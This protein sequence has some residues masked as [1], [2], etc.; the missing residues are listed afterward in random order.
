MSLMK[1]LTLGTATAALLSVPL[2]SGSAI[3]QTASGTDSGAYTLDNAAEFTDLDL[4]VDGD[5]QSID[6]T[7]EHGAEE[8]VS[9]AVLEIS[10]QDVTDPVE[11]PLR[12]L[13]VDP[14]NTLGVSA[15][16]VSFGT[17]VT[18]T[19]V[20]TLVV[21]TNMGGAADDDLTITNVG[22]SGSTS[23]GGSLVAGTP[24][25]TLEP[26]E[27]TSLRITFE[28]T[29]AGPSNGAIEV[30]YDD[31]TGTQTSNIRVGGTAQD[32]NGEY[33]PTPDDAEA[34]RFGDVVEGETA[35][36]TV[37]MSNTAPA[38]AG[39]VSIDTVEITN[40]PDGEF[41][42]PDEIFPEDPTDPTLGPGQTRDVPVTVRPAADGVI[43]AN[44][45][46]TYSNGT[47]DTDSYDLT[48][49]G[50]DPMLGIEAVGPGEWGA[51]I[52]VTVRNSTRTN[53]TFD[54]TVRYWTALGET[55]NTA[56][57]TVR[58]Q[59]EPDVE[60]VFTEL[61]TNESSSNYYETVVNS[62]ST[63]VEV[64][65]IGT[66]RPE[67]G[68][69]FLEVP[70]DD[71]TDD[72]VEL[73]HYRGDE[74]AP[75][76]ERTGL[77]GFAETDD[78]SLVSVPD[79]NAI[80][81]LTGEIVSHCENLQD[82]FAIL[83]AT[84]GAD[85]GNLPPNTA[86]SEYAAI[87]YPHIRIVDPETGVRKLV[88]PGGH[89]AGIY[90][91]SDAQ[92]GVWKAPAN[93]TVRG[94]VELERPVTKADQDRLNPN[95][96]NAIRSFPDRGIRV[97][98][99]RTTSVN[100]EWKYINVRR[101]FLFIEESIDEGTQWAVFESNTEELWARV[102]QSVR[103]FLTTVWRNGGLAGTTEDEAFFVKADRTTMTQTDIDNGK[104]IVEVG[105]APVKPAEFV[106]FRI[107]QWT[108]GLEGG[109]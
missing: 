26:G 105:V 102:R 25:M 16:E 75:R 104:L 52:A 86:V 81:G 66:E 51:R 27:T 87:Y 34:L 80:D 72:D 15:I 96:V 76:G 38:G 62:G 49:T 31:G 22:R 41:S 50:V 36:Q 85:P 60:E 53:E 74:D 28:P 70:P 1:R 39:D 5:P 56:A 68:T 97:W 17:A 7:V 67:N 8:E 58:M 43:E 63:I 77:A 24:P 61:T 108:E 109:S 42:L 19:A 57:E 103:N 45:E 83:Q 14:A 23:Y 101:L 69:F 78:I 44:L 59:D 32:V 89:M 6:V 79:E 90:A 13:V 94:A 82:R 3:A 107:T 29:S 88:P 84:Q 92:E 12:A 54:M 46:I 21:L 9:D 71:E 40:D 95:G 65:R 37:T 100:P 93:E 20:D 33:T 106:I 55:G 18:N 73:R 47:S 98:G 48:A 4:T 2:A 30:E 99:A 35:V 10:I 64:E 91:R 11:V